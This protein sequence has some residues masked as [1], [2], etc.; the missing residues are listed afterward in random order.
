[1]KLTAK[2]DRI[3]FL[4]SYQIKDTDNLNKILEGDPV[5]FVNVRH[6]FERL[7][8]AYLFAYSKT[9][10]NERKTFKQFIT[11]W[12]LNKAKTSKNKMTFREIEAHWRPSNTYCAFCNIKYGIV[13]KMETFNEDKRRIM[14]ILGLEEEE[15]EQR[16][17]V[18]GGT[19]IQNLTKECF[20]NITDIDKNAL[21]DIYKY[22]FLMF[23]Y[24]PDLY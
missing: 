3:D 12:V 7:V 5:S 22:D 2:T 8:S 14:E 19:E 4:H 9:K 13:S 1:M 10:E 11:E 16:K 15:K 21:I 17:N 6:P 20:K 18:N 24:D 23:D